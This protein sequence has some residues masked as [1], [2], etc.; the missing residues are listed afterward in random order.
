MSEY[1]QE[2]DQ[3]E[4]EDHGEE[5]EETED[6]GDGA[7]EVTEGV[8]GVEEKAGKVKK[9]LKTV[10]KAKKAPKVEKGSKSGKAEKPKKMANLA[11]TAKSP[12]KVT[13]VTKVTKAAKSSKAAKPESNKSGKVAEK[14]TGKATG[15]AKRYIREGDLS[16][17]ASQARK[18]DKKAAKKVVKV[19]EAHRAVRQEAIK[20]TAKNKVKVGKAAGKAKLAKVPDTDDDV[21]VSAQAVRTPRT[22]TLYS[23]GYS[24]PTRDG[25]PVRSS[26]KSRTHMRTKQPTDSP[27][28]CQRNS[29]SPIWKRDMVT[30]APGK[31]NEDK[32][33]CRRC[34]KI[35]VA[36][37][38]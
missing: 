14:T 31:G 11:K 35:I 36:Q 24:R 33:T 4:H 6:H 37:A 38:A 18:L 25:E 8:E 9:G 29:F 10:K 1:E 12:S 23:P 27:I 15:K 19:N 17:K 32:V 5:H 30:V 7:G 2:T 21:Q 26:H 22:S 16:K 13:K 20:A 3:E 34:S 28:L